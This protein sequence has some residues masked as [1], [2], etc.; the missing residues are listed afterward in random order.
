[1]AVCQNFSKSSCYS[2]PEGAFINKTLYQG[3][4]N[5]IDSACFQGGNGPICRS[6]LGGTPFLEQNGTVEQCA[7]I[8]TDLRNNN[9]EMFSSI[10]ALQPGQPAPGWLLSACNW[11]QQ[12]NIQIS[13]S[14]DYNNLVVANPNFGQQ[15]ATRLGGKGLH[16]IF[17]L[18]MDAFFFL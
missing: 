12:A 13:T 3:Q 6:A 16:V 15:L 5:T 1:M 17:E 18:I 9:S 11:N 14:Q 4:Y 7:G 2:S 10:Q 8:M